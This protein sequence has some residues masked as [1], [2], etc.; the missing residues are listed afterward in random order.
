M[1]TQKSE[2]L[3]L[4][5]WTRRHVHQSLKWTTSEQG[6]LFFSGLRSPR[7]CLRGAPG[8]SG[9]RE[10]MEKNLLGNSY[11]EESKS[12]S[13][14]QIHQDVQIEP[15]FSLTRYKI[16]SLAPIVSGLFRGPARHSTV[17]L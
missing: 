4:L 7:A 12:E 6:G 2:A 16:S 9:T 17:T 13:I 15:F 11:I 1:I 3:L 8:T 14:H 10:Q 5:G